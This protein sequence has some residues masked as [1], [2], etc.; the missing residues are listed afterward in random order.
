MKKIINLIMLSVLCFLFAGCEEND[1]VKIKQYTQKCMEEV[2]HQ[3][4]YKIV[5]DDISTNVN[6]QRMKP[7]EVINAKRGMTKF[8][9]DVTN[10]MDDYKTNQLAGYNNA[11]YKTLTVE[12]AAAIPA[13]CS[14]PCLIYTRGKIEIGAN[15]SVFLRDLDSK[16]NSKI[17]VKYK[18]NTSIGNTDTAWP[19]FCSVLGKVEQNTNGKNIINTD[20]MLCVYLYPVWTKNY[21]DFIFNH[22]FFN[23][24]EES[25]I[26]ACVADYKNHR[27][28]FTPSK[29]NNM[30]DNSTRASS[31]FEDKGFSINT[32]REAVDFILNGLVFYEDSSTMADFIVKEYKK[33]KEKFT[34]Y[35][36]EETNKSRIED[37]YA[38]V[39]YANIELPKVYAEKLADK[40]WLIKF[41][42]R[43]NFGFMSVSSVRNNFGS[44]Y[45][46]KVIGRNMKKEPPQGTVSY[47]ILDIKNKKVLSGNQRG[48]QSTDMMWNCKFNLGRIK[49]FRTTKETQLVW[50]DNPFV[51]VDNLWRES[52][53]KDECEM[54]ITED[55][56]QNYI[57][58]KTSKGSLENSQKFNGETGQ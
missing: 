1:P 30:Q 19:F 32:G 11:P 6:A 7:D 13:S 49:G 5:N 17:E 53:L 22:D 20:K 43:K 40:T 28:S 31:A 58:N 37:G 54:D 50:P 14:E 33:E 36:L 10:L 51:N 24:G 38:P 2:K 35:Y 26:K 34:G 57:A 21:R 45:Y 18:T 29:K 15:D 12:Q 3:N 23:A 9:E 8:L 48:Y 41:V 39:S 55:V 16:N 42:W 4:A 56:I 47:L 25:Q 27:K 46:N 52:G 44:Y